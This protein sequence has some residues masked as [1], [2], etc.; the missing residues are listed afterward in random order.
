MQTHKRIFPCMGDLQRRTANLAEKGGY[1]FF[2]ECSLR[3]CNCT[4]FPISVL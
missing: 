2:S 1:P 3:V 4:S